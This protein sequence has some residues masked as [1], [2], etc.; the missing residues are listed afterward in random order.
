M[1]SNC[2]HNSRDLHASL[3]AATPQSN[4]WGQSR[5]LDH[6]A[7][8]P[9]QPVVVHR[10]NQQIRDNRHRNKSRRTEAWISV[11][12]ILIK[13]LHFL[14]MVSL[15]KETEKSTFYFLFLF[16]AAGR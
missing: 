13:Q 16:H 2:S 3:I 1:N 4:A 14:V 8:L 11:E 7:R 9:T 6:S 5:G 12:T 15:A 10:V